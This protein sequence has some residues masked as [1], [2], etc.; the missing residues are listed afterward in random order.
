MLH[1]RAANRQERDEWADNIEE[2]Y[3]RERRRNSGNCFQNQGVKSRAHHI[4]ISDWRFDCTFE[5]VKKLPINQKILERTTWICLISMFRQKFSVSLFMTKS[6]TGRIVRELDCN[7]GFILGSSVRLTMESFKC[8]KV[9]GRGTFGSVHLVYRKD[10]K[11]QKRMAMKTIKKEPIEI[12]LTF[13]QRWV[14]TRARNFP[15][16]EVFGYLRVRTRVRLCVRSSLPPAKLNSFSKF[17][18]S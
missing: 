10:D 3:N 9:L 13:C 12:I 15:V 1:F 16:S 17:A 18:I 4:L 5:N 11:K 2:I 6:R 8:I 14:D 7:Q